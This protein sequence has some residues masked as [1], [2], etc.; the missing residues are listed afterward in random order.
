[1]DYDEFRRLNTKDQQI[2]SEVKHTLTVMLDKLY[3]TPMK[4]EEY[5]QILSLD[6]REKEIKNMFDGELILDHRYVDN[7]EYIGLTERMS[8]CIEKAGGIEP[9]IAK[10][11]ED[12]ECDIDGEREPNESSIE[13]WMDEFNEVVEDE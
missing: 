13:N 9:S 11:M 5:E 8:E 4:R 2:V 6:G 10:I 3:E 7:S 1:M 12:V